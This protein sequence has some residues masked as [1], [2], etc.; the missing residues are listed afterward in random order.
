[1]AKRSHHLD[2]IAGWDLEG[3]ERVYGNR[4]LGGF[5]NFAIA[6]AGRAGAN[7]FVGA[8]DDRMNR[9]Q[10][11]IPTA[12]SDVVGVADFIA[13]LRSATADITYF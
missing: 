2:I 11:Q 7:A 4:R 12:L 9:L 8:F 5:L 3:S 6:N 1:M 10:V 13:E